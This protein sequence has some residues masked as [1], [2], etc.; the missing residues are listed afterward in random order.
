MRLMERGE[1]LPLIGRAEELALRGVRARR[2]G[3]GGQPCPRESLHQARW[4]R[5]AAARFRAVP[6][7]AGACRPLKPLGERE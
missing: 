1:E 5:K 7:R 3:G 4:V 2:R 6:C